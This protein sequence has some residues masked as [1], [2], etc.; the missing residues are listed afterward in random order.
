ML[1]MLIASIIYPICGHEEDR[2][3]NPQKSQFSQKITWRI[4]LQVSRFG[5]HT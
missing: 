3:D 4:K 1:V 5:E 2:K